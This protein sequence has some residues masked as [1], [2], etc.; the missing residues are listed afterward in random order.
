MAEAIPRGEFREAP[1]A[2]HDVHVSHYQWLVSAM[3]D[4]LGSH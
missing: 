3:T 2:G 1:G 4:W